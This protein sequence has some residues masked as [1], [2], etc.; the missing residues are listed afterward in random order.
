MY[1]LEYIHF[2]KEW[3]AYNVQIIMVKIVRRD[4]KRKHVTALS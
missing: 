2:L 1:H 3:R 4:L